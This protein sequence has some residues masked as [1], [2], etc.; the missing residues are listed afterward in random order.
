MSNNGLSRT[1]FLV[2]ADLSGDQNGGRLAQAIHAIAPEVRLLGAGGDVMRQNGV[3]VRVMSTH[4]SIVGLPQSFRI[5]PE[6]VSL[7][8]RLR[9]LIRE[10]R[11]DLVV[12]IDNE[13]M[14]LMLAKW[15]HRK[16]IPAIFFFPPQVW[17]WGRWRLPAVVRIARRV[18]CAFREEAEIYRAGGADTLWVGHPLRDTVEI[19]SDPQAAMREL[20]LDPARPL[21]AL[22]PGSRRAEIDALAAA[23]LGAARLLKQR[24]PSL[25]FAIPLA[26]ES[27]RA[28]LEA[29]A[30]SAGVADAVI[31]R[32]KS[33]AVL[34]QAR[35]ALQCSGTATLETALLGIPSVITYRCSSLNY[36]FANRFRL[37][38]YIGMSNI[39]LGEMV[40][41]EYFQK[42][43]DPQHLGDEVW[44]LL[45]DAPRRQK[46]QARL[47]EM[48]ALLGSPGAMAR[49]ASAVLDLL[50]GY[51]HVNGKAAAVFCDPLSHP[52][53]QEHERVTDAD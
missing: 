17:F 30:R 43:V 12:L 13:S 45:S 3:D 52:A 37:V 47:A 35:V 10:A 53:L 50:P 24:D 51:A 33:Y 8:L 9:R 6:L 4:A 31:Y 11:P 44:S 14:N 5:I 41:P 26:Q 40:Q 15:L 22:M 28:P 42:N 7:Y 49:T 23:M 38:D 1:I 25:Q 36:F 21:V 46:I 19:E 20:G 39:L 48:K 2:T 32:P 16:G 27:L 34:S 18:M 29:S